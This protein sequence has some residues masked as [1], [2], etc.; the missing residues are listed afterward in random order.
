MARYVIHQYYDKDGNPNGAVVIHTERVAWNKV[1]HP[2]TS[3]PIDLIDFLALAKL[4]PAL[5]ATAGYV[6]PTATKGLPAGAT[7]WDVIAAHPDVEALPGP[8]LTATQQ[9]IKAANAAIQ[10]QV[11]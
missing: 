4:S 11:G 8:V 10:I 9:T 3:V 7:H 2:T 6:Q 1:P 5:Q